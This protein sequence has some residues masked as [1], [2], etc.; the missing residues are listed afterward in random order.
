MVCGGSPPGRRSSPNWSVS[1]AGTGSVFTTLRRSS[2]GCSK[3]RSGRDPQSFRSGCVAVCSALELRVCLPRLGPVRPRGGD[4]LQRV[5]GYRACLCG[6]GGGS[7]G[8]L[9]RPVPVRP[10]RPG[11]HVR[12]GRG[13]SLRRGGCV[14]LR[15]DGPW[16]TVANQA[17]FRTVAGR[18]GYG[19]PAGHGG[20][21]PI[22]PG[23][24]RRRLPDGVLT[25][26]GS[27]LCTAPTTPAPRA[28]QLLGSRAPCAVRTSRPSSFRGGLVC[29][30][31]RF[32]FHPRGARVGEKSCL[33]A[34]QGHIRDRSG[35]WVGTRSACGDVPHYGV[36]VCDS[37]VLL[38]LLASWS[39][40]L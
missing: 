3:S 31:S 37:W 19:G 18:R 21:G 5:V 16:P 22:G 40:W 39:G 28:R 33:R 25:G 26:S 11:P 23:I 12:P 20:G 10:E 27:S 9:R 30:P 36:P 14:W 34:R 1:R 38:R 35:S 32:A 7:C 6:T 2:F 8:A 29:A 24:G 17:T 15:G 4:F 13:R